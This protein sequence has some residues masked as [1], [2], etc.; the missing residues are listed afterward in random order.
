M[1]LEEREIKRSLSLVKAAF[2]R[3]ADWQ[4]NKG[5]AEYSGVSI[6]GEFV[7]ETDDVIK[8]HFFL[9]FDTYRTTWSGH[10]TIGKHVYLW[11]SA[12][13][14]DAHLVDT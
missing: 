2:P 14:G 9:T 5:N 3:L 11:S 10:L 4:Y 7:P 8:R 1:I 12:D 6:W 13:V